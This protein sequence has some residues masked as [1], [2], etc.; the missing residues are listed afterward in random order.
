MAADS[1][2]AADDPAT[3]FSPRL[4]P[5]EATSWGTS[6]AP[7]AEFAREIGR[8]LS[9]VPAADAPDEA[10]PPGWEAVADGLRTYYLH[11]ATGATQWELPE[12]GATRELSSLSIAEVGRLLCSL[13]MDA[14]AAGFAEHYVDGA[15]LAQVDGHDLEK[16]GVGVGAVRRGLLARIDKLKTFGV[17]SQLLRDD[18]GGPAPA[19][20]GGSG[21]GGSGQDAVGGGSESGGGG[22]SNPPAQAEVDAM[23][24]D[25]L[26]VALRRWALDAATASACC[27][28][29]ARLCSDDGAAAVRDAACEGGAAEAV[30]AAL[31]AHPTDGAP[32]RAGC[33]ALAALCA[34]ADAD[35]GAAD[36][37]AVARRQRCS[38][39]GGLERAV[40][41]LRAPGELAARPE[42]LE[43][44]MRAVGLICFGAQSDDAAA[45]ARRRHAAETGALLAAIR[46]M[47]AHPG[48]RGVQAQG[49]RLLATLAAGD[50]ALEERAKAE[51]A[52]QAAVAA[53]QAHPRDDEVRLVAG[54]LTRL[55]GGF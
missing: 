29:L 26:L 14:L 18:G 43:H 3:L 31:A 12:P 19:G 1:Q 44:S 54:R 40:L 6:G 35:A 5:S 10:L 23:G 39:C 16:L 34:G 41:A 17:P 27:E 47:R 7:R 24:L 33:M 51:G 8:R 49:C 21:E 15:S 55:F 42:V 28:R 20:G 37:A 22:A 30:V 48:S 4:P 45:A 36:A 25:E 46:A 13:G 9:A 53:E 38:E 50:E 52:L 2:P 32:Q 11:A